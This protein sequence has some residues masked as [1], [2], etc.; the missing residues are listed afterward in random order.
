MNMK[1]L[2]K[3]RLKKA[4]FFL[5]Y[6]VLISLDSDAQTYVTW[7]NVGG[8]NGIIGN[9]PGGGIVTATLAGPGNPLSFDSPPFSD[10]NL[11]VTGNQTFSTIGPM[12]MPPAQSMVFNFS[13]PV[14]IT[15][16]NVAD[17]DRSNGGWDDSY[18]FAGIV[19]ANTNSTNCVSTVNGVT[20]TADVFGAGNEEFATWTNSCNLIN[21]FA[22]NYLAPANLTT[23]Y[24]AYSMEVCVPFNGINLGPFCV[25]STATLPTTIACGITGTWSPAMVNTSVPGTFNYTFTPNPG[26]VLTCPLNRNIT[27]T[28]CCLPTLTSATTINTMVQQ[29]RSGWIRSTDIVNYSAGGVGS[30]VVYHAGNF[31]ELNPGFET[32][33]AAKFTAYPESC[34]GN[35][36]YRPQG[37][38]INN[39]Q[40]LVASI[41][42]NPVR[43]ESQNSMRA[44]IA[45]VALSNNVLI[46][47]T[48]ASSFFNI[49]M[50]KNRFKRITITTVDGKKISEQSFAGTNKCQVDISRYA[51]GI[52]I[53]NIITDTGQ[54]FSKK[55]IK[56]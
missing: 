42:Q 25:N 56:N 9:Y 45:N 35:Y 55:L 14:I 29:E 19:F 31:I 10:L 7:N 3:H 15:R 36:S 26:Q 34:T 40:D 22:I 39:I 41:K 2:Y 44:K 5:I 18:N 27:I 38:I 4:L 24:L 8:T 43:Y 11:V 21:T 16:L 54:T 23:A 12:N 37:N 13:V 1:I 6:I 51:K 32:G 33:V 20:A 50:P 52:Y 48:P 46:Y 30:G 28:D 49:V 17:I 47:P 53:V